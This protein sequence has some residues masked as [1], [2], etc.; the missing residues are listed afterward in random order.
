M[1]GSVIE[2]RSLGDVLDVMGTVRSAIEGVLTATA[3]SEFVIDVASIAA[4]SGL[5]IARSPYHTRGSPV[6]AAPCP[7]R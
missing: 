4:L 2:K 5:A 3:N 7:Q 6:N 1:V